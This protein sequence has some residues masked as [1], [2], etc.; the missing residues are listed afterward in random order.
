MAN[1]MSLLNKEN[2]SDSL[3]YIPTVAVEPHNRQ[4]WYL[5]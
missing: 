3:E 2:R 1:P 4:D 5:S